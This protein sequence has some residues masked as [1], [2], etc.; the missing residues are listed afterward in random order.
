MANGGTLFL[1]EIGD[2]PASAQIKLLRIL[3]ERRVTR[4]G[5]SQ[6]RPIDIRV[7]AATHRNLEA[8]VA[9]GSFRHDL[10]YRL[11]VLSLHLP[12]LRQRL[13]DLPELAIKLLDRI[14]QRMS[15]AQRTMDAQSISALASQAWPGNVR[16]LENALERAVNWA[17]DET[18]LRLE[19]FDLMPLV[20]ESPATQPA[21]KRAST[22]L[23]ECER[24]SIE[25]AIAAHDGNILRAAASLGI[26]RNTIYR[27][28]RSYRLQQA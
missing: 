27:K 16:Q 10:Y 18:V 26:S 23:E 6:E 20:D 28:L 9:S 13:A 7:I 14:C 12:A 4:L 11:N 24:Q 3:Q 22:R 17:G 5:E 19:H 2:M 1:D 21:L 8:A 25:A 15:I